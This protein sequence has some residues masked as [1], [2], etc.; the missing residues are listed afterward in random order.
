MTKTTTKRTA[1]ER[2]SFNLLFCLLACESVPDGDKEG[3][4][5]SG[6]A[7]AVPLHARHPRLG[8]DGE[9]ARVVHNTLPHPRHCPLQPPHGKQSQIITGTATQ[10]LNMVQM[11]GQ[12]MCL[13]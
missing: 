5:Y 13:N 11:G 4:E 10:Y 2:N 1:L 12:K 3:G 7:A 9:A 6:G 8:L